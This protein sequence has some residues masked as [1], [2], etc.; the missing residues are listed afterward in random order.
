[1]VI[2]TVPLVDNRWCNL[3]RI[4]HDTRLAL[5]S[6]LLKLINQSSNKKT[7]VQIEKKK[8]RRKTKEIDSLFMYSWMLTRIAKKNKQWRVHFYFSSSMMFICM[9][10][11][12]EEGM[13]EWKGRYRSRWIVNRMVT[14][15]GPSVRTI[16]TNKMSMSLQPHWTNNLYRRQ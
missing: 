15:S 5:A 10:R 3:W 1:M 12:C 6:T 13:N 14:Y 8:R 16:R 4:N 2:G 11:Q 7:W 9:R